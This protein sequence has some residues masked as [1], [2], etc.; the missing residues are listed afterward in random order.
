M[1]IL[2]SN[3]SPAL[4]AR[5]VEEKDVIDEAVVDVEDLCLNGTDI[6]A[7][8]LADYDESESDCIGVHND[9][10]DTSTEMTSKNKTDHNDVSEE[11]N[12]KANQ[13]ERSS[14]KTEKTKCCQSCCG[15]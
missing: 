5:P 12:D 4:P 13:K 2:N 6:S 8:V 10:L 15:R 11:R 7:P 3:H 1:N 9:D 14:N